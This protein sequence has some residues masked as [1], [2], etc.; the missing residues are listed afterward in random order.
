MPRTSNRRWKGC[1]LCKFHK[2]AQQGDAN[3]M[4]IRE[5]R[6]FGAKNMW[7]VNRHDIE[8]D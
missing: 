6:K 7:R 3:R 4:P 1:L 2:Y 8:E 5:L